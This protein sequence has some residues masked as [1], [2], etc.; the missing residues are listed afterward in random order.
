M[1]ALGETDAGREDG[2]DGRA[3]TFL[4]LVPGKGTIDTALVVP[5]RRSVRHAPGGRSPL[6]EAGFA[7]CPPAAC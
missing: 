5:V 1:H 6:R 4:A 3:R 2:A 7:T